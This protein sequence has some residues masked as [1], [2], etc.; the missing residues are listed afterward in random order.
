M[1]PPGMLFFCP[2]NGKHIPI[3]TIGIVLGFTLVMIEQ[4]QRQVADKCL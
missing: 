4:M 2:R 3:S 1:T